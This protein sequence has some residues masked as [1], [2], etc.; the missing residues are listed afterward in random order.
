M[1]QKGSAALAKL[2]Q[3]QA[4]VETVAGMLCTLYFSLRAKKMPTYLIYRI[5]IEAAK[6]WFAKKDGGKNV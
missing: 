3:A 1:I 4:G 6:A 2:D 5:V